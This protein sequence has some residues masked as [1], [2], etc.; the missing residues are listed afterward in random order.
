MV[1]TTKTIHAVNV[2]RNQ[3]QYGFV[4]K[5]KKKTLKHRE[6]LHGSYYPPEPWFT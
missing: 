4:K 6:A 1:T 5:K 2:W 3:M